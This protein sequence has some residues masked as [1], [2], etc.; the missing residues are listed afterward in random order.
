MGKGC[1]SPESWDFQGGESVPIDKLFSWVIDQ[2]DIEGLTISGGEPVDQAEPLTELCIHLREKIDIGIMCYTGYKHENLME[3]GTPAQKKLLE[4]IDILID[5]E[6][7]EDRHSNLLWRASSNQRII[8]LSNRYE[9]Q[10]STLTF[11]TDRS[12]GIECS[13]SPAGTILIAG[14]PS[15]ARFRE[16]FL[17]A[18]Y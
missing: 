4:S 9:K 7:L 2:K 1:I 12:A 3:E 16:E 14:V 17:K 10:I 15:E 5:G 11:D 18:L 6:Y 13:V 8:C